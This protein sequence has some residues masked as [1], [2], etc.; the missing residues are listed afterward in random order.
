MKNTF[1]HKILSNLLIAPLLALISCGS[2]AQTTSTTGDGDEAPA[3]AQPAA[4]VTADDDANDANTY[5]IQPGDILQILVWREKDLSGEMMVRPDGGLSF[6]LVREIAAAGKTAE[7]LRKELVDRLAKYVPDPVVTVSVKQGLG[8]K[9]YVIGK[10]N[11]PGEYIATRNLDVMQALSVAGGPTPFASVNN[12]KI[13]RR[14]NGEQQ[15][16]RFKYSRVEKGKDL[17]Q[18]IVLQG[19]DVIVVP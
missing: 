13:L 17:E 12:I 6:P 18:N 11:K 9:I 19:G 4:P 3:N 5:V 7:Q 1:P 2:I 8:N 10:V 16:F 14:I 15:T